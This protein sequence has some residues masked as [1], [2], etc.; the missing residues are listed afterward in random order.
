MSLGA[1]EEGA[2]EARVA[3]LVPVELQV[4]KQLTA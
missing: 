3:V 4:V 2:L 1:A